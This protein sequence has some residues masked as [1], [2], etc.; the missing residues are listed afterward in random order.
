MSSQLTKSNITDIDERQPLNYNLLPCN[1]L[2]HDVGE[3]HVYAHPKPGTAAYKQTLYRGYVHGRLRNALT[4]SVIILFCFKQET[5][6]SNINLN[7]SINKI[8]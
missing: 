4:I 1:M 7:H 6:L 3:K 5:L 8:G 2:K